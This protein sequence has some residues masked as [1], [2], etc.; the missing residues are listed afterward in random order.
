[1]HALG[2]GLSEYKQALRPLRSIADVQA[3]ILARAKTTPKGEWIV[4]PRTLP[5]R[6]KEMRM[7]TRA[8]LDV[9]KDHPVAFDGSYVWAANSK[10]L[11]I[12]GITRDTPN[13][14]GGEVVKDERGEPNG[15]LR[16]GA[17]LLKG[18]QRAESSAMTKGASAP[19]HAATVC[20]GRFNRSRG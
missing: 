1:M 7:P 14:P 18:A 8:D 10:A 11:A 17:Q 20:R 13:P 4:V 15:I 12:S 3:Y 5:P 6:L 19:G 2:A 9:V 16:N